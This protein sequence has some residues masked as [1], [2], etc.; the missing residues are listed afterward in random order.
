MKPPLCSMYAVNS[1]TCGPQYCC[2]AHAGS[3]PTLHL[4]SRR[5]WRIINPVGQ[6]RCWEHVDKVCVVASHENMLARD[7]HRGNHQ[8]S[9]A[10]SPAM[11]LTQMFHDGCAG[12][13]K[14]DDVE[15][16]EHLLCVQQALVS[17]RRFGWRCLQGKLTPPA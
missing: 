8:V 5:V 2:A 17:K 11:L 4:P 3:R 13:V 6:L 9:I 12:H 15:L 16:G 1:C 7:D 14:H 10:L